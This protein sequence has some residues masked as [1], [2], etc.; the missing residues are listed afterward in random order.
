MYSNRKEC[1]QKC[2]GTLTS[3]GQMCCRCS[4]SHVLSSKTSRNN[5]NTTFLRYIIGS[6]TSSITWSK[7]V[8]PYQFIPEIGMF[9]SEKLSM[10]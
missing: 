9:E 8:L 10:K 5:D 7:N 4:N 1:Y 3:G 6:T 2:A